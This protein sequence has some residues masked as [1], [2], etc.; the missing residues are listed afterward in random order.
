M[1]TQRV[2]E[3]LET[4]EIPVSYLAFTNETAQPCPFICYFYAGDNDFI[5]DNTNYASI[6]RLIV[7][8]YT[9][10]KDFSLEKTVE[11]TLN[12]AGLVFSREESYIST[13]QMFQIVYESEVIING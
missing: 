1:T 8:L 2:K 9:D 7:E 4:T 13:E 3:I 5:A 10:Y 11:E 6:N 12:A